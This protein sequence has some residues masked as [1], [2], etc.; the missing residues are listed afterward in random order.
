MGEEWSKKGVVYN[1]GRKSSLVVF[2]IC[3]LCFLAACTVKGEDNPEKQAGSSVGETQKEISGYLPEWKIVDASIQDGILMDYVLSGSRLHYV[4]LTAKE[5]VVY[6]YIGSVDILEDEEPVL[7]EVEGMVNCLFTDSEGK[8][9]YVRNNINQETEKEEWFVEKVTAKGEA[10]VQ[11]DIS[12]I[13]EGKENRIPHA[14]MDK[15]G[16]LYLIIDKEGVYFLAVLNSEGK[17]IRPLQEMEG[18]PQVDRMAE[19]GI[20]LYG[21]VDNAV[22]LAQPD[23][24]LE[25]LEEVS[26]ERGNLIVQAV[27]E[28]ALYY[29]QGHSLMEYHI[30]TKSGETIL[31]LNECNAVADFIQDIAVLE[32]GRIVILQK[33][34]QNASRLEVALLTKVP[35]ED[36]PVK[37]TIR[38]GMPLRDYSLDA[39]VAEYNRMHSGYRI[40]IVAYSEN[41]KGEGLR[42][43]NQEIIN[44]NGPD[45]I[46]LRYLSGDMGAYLD[47]DVLEDLNP[48]LD[49]GTVK[50]EDFVE[51]LLE[52]YTMNGHLY[53]VPSAFYI[54]TIIGKKSDLPSGMF[55]TPDTFMDYAE[56]LADD[57]RMFA[58]EGKMMMLQY[59]LINNIDEYVDR[60][61]KVSC[62]AGT[63]FER[64]LKFS[65]EYFREK[66]I[67]SLEEIHLMLGKGTVKLYEARIS[68]MYQLQEYRCYFGSEITCIGYPAADGRS[69]SR[70]EGCGVILGI[71][72]QSA[73][74]DA[75]WEFISAQLTKV[76]Q[77]EK[78]GD[79]QTGF[80]SRMDV[81]DA[82][83]ESVRTPYYRYDDAGNVLTD[84]EGN[85]VQAPKKTVVSYAEDGTEIDM[86][87]Y[88]S[89]QE[90]VELVK[91]LISFGTGDNLDSYV[92]RDIVLEEANAYFYG[93]KTLEETLEIIEG[94]VNLYLE[95]KEG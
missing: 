74:K 71:N 84:E 94:R 7:T 24:N 92:I 90:E 5:G 85:P 33:G 26:N 47:K 72:S 39:A 81:L 87:F 15:E 1:M 51:G 21:Y 29:I 75:A 93:Q 62:F 65:N 30:K 76:A 9:W 59:L 27:T 19:K 32:D 34:I 70:I 42:K 57:A 88:A 46:D 11:T 44:G 78:T 64:M 67:F 73:Y 69:G 10:S 13:V 28:D 4:V 49:G 22:M 80:P 8:I 36:M 54:D 16:N 60:E 12:G 3:I 41:D 48:Y 50:R 38:L 18:T 53:A 20:V 14:A 63:E 91:G 43:M 40:E 55:W 17:S 68:D 79:F 89:T 6:S 77:T 86:F 45:I 35:A 23:G 52:N 58:Y 31:D 56:G 66:T 25:E 2:V 37:Q 83:F 82:Y 95:E 61:A